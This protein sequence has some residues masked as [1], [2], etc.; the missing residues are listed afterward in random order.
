MTKTPARREFESAVF[1]SVNVDEIKRIEE[2]STDEL[3]IWRESEG[4]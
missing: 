2:L 3:R 4:C 1:H